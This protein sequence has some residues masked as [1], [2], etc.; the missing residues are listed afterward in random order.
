MPVCAI[1][2]HGRSGVRCNGRVPTWSQ[3]NEV[4]S[5][6]RAATTA[7]NRIL[8][9]DPTKLVFVSGLVSSSRL[10]AV[11]YLPIQLAVPD[12]LVYVAHD[13]SFWHPDAY[14]YPLYE[15]AVE[16]HWGFIVG[17]T[18]NM[19]LFVSEF[20]TCN[21]RITCVEED[22][23]GSGDGRLMQA[24]KWFS[25]VTRFLRDRDADFAYWP[26]NGS[27]CRGTNRESGANEGYGLLNMCWN[28][29]VYPPLLEA[30]QALQPPANT[31]MAW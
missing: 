28:A 24:G 16:R 14:G 6:Y 1:L 15:E 26:L 17:N 13:Y 29:Y 20:G 2:A 8:A 9:I 31:T 10:G 21:D 3:R 27:T 23:N 18:T 4:T 11:R 25:Y 30:L 22:P 7:G 12:R 19:P 5:W